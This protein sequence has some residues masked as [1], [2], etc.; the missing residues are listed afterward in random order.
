MSVNRVIIHTQVLENYGYNADGQLSDIPNWKPKGSRDFYLDIDADW[1]LYTDAKG[2]L[3]RMLSEHNN[4]AF[5]YVYEDYEIIWN[6]PVFLGDEDK[7]R[8]THD[9]LQEEATKAIKDAEEFNRKSQVT[10]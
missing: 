6:E 10:I 7:Y 8:D 1:L 5:K 3:S 9:L 2:I 4:K